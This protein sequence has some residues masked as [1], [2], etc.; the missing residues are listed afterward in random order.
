MEL[1][2]LLPKMKKRIMIGNAASSV[3]AIRPGQSGDPP[4]VCERKMPKR[5]GQRRGISS[6]VTPAAARSIRSRRR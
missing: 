5:D 4:G 1:T 2:T 6:W 3:M